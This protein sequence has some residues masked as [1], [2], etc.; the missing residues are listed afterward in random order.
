MSSTLLDPRVLDASTVIPKPTQAIYLPIAVEGQ[1]DAAGGA[2]INTPAS[3]VRVDDANTAFGPNS[4]LAR[5]INVILNRGAGPVIGIAS[6]KATLPTTVQRQAAWAVL[7][8]DR[9]VRIRLTDSE[10]QA[11]LV[12]LATSAA[13]ANLLFYKQIA[14]MGMP[15]G[16][17]KANLIAAATAIAGAGTDPATRS[18][19]VG[20]GVYDES[21]TL[22]G[23]S[24]AAACAAAEIAK[25]SDPTNDLDIWPMPLLT[26]VEKDAAG[27]P[28]FRRKV[29]S[30]AAVDDYEDL[31]QGGVSPFQ[32]ARVPGGVITTHFRTVFTTAGTFDSLYTRIIADQVFVDVREYIYDSN[33]LRSPNNDA[34]R[35]RIASGVEAQLRERGS[36]IRP[37][38]QADGTQGY[39]VSVTSSPD[40]RQVIVGYEGIV[41]RGIS[42]IKVAANLTVPL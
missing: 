9:T 25:N 38:N 12:A 6:A 16:T 35:S 13:N 1:M 27:L 28:V 23:G 7:E 42:T 36:W 31:L 39:N 21:G 15:A 3:F 2:S 4:S 24:F 41:V 29:V 34:T 22:R 26:D 11:D 30:G 33:F 8:S 20:P 14:L 32:P 17:S 37:V 10:V 19:L 40:N 5:I 18:V